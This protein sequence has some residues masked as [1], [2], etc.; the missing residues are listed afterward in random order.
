MPSFGKASLGKLVTCHPD[1]Q[2][3]MQEVVK[4][5]DITITCGSR[6]KLDQDTAFANHTSQLKWPQSKHNKTPSM[7]VDCVPY[8]EMWDSQE[9]FYELATI[10]KQ[11]AEE[12]NIPIKWGGDWKKFVD[13]PHWEL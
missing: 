3:L 10:I 1:I 12:L 13:L 5:R 7:A 6:G 2:R 4:R 8:P 9:A 11:V